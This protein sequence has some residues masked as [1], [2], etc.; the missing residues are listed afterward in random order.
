MS[1]INPT[2]TVL[3]IPPRKFPVC[4]PTQ[5]ASDPLHRAASAQRNLDTAPSRTHSTRLNPRQLPPGHQT[6]QSRIERQEPS[7][8][9]RSCP[10]LN[11]RGP[12]DSTPGRP[13]PT[14]GVSPKPQAPAPKSDGKDPLTRSPRR[15]MKRTEANNMRSDKLDSAA[16]DKEADKHNLTARQTRH[17]IA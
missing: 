1:S 3:H 6:P 8:R 15:P 9:R 4:D 5:T 17:T 11:G 12:L 10:R 7:D 16:S 2:S 13:A 14:P